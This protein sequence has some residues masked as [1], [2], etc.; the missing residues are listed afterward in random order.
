[1]QHEIHCRPLGV[2]YLSDE[3]ETL[4]AA[5]VRQGHT[6]PH[7]CSTG[8]CGTCKVRILEGEV[9]RATPKECA[10]TAGEEA[11][12]LALLCQSRA[13]SP[14]TLELNM[15]DETADIPVRR[16]TG[17]VHE[18]E[19]VAND[20]MRITVK[21][22][23]GDTL[24]YAAGQHVNVVLGPSVRRCV[25]IAN[26]P[27]QDGLVEL[28][29]KHYGGI[30]STHVFEK[31]KAGDLL[32]MEGPL[33]V[34]AIRRRTEKPIIFVASGTGF[35]PIKSMVERLIQEGSRRPVAFYWAGRRPADL[36]M[37]ELA[38]SWERRAGLRYVPVLA[39]PLPEDGWQGKTGFV[40]DVIAEDFPDLS[41]HEL[42]ICGA[43]VLIDAARNVLQARCGLRD[44]Y[45]DEFKKS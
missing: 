44:F 32:R 27:D 23:E 10:L 19:Q 12:G 37:D 18:L 17:R 36:Y 11:E 33:G 24:R 4:L 20:V 22:P 5:A 8:R 6:V 1:M 7:S 31:M 2:T 40:Q 25:S 15:I 34:F 9:E 28:H 43:P 13:R 16:I 3:D 45:T 29:L 30:L 14:V 35:A 21:L 42:Y 38:R 26:S 39:Q 41:G